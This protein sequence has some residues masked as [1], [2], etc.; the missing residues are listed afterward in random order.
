MNSAAYSIAPD[1]INLVLIGPNV[2]SDFQSIAQGINQKQRDY[3]IIQHNVTSPT[4]NKSPGPGRHE[5]IGWG[6]GAAGN[7]GLRSPLTGKTSKNSTMDRLF[8]M[9]PKIH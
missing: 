2:D 9:Q 8:K 1:N 6:Q 7:V 4:W 5:V 3:S